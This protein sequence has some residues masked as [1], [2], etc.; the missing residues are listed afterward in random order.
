MRVAFFGGTFDPPHIGHVLAAAY[1]R[2]VGFDH[3]LVAPVNAHAFD[4]QPAAFGHRMKM[5]ELAFRTVDGVSVSDI[6]GRLSA[7]NYTL[8]TLQALQGEHP[9]WSLELLIGTDVLSETPRWHQFERIRELAPP[10]VLGR[11][12]APTWPGVP[13]LLPAISSSSIRE[14]LALGPETNADSELGHW[15][16]APVLDY[17]AAQQLYR[18]AVAS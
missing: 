8:Q 7:P 15:V 10:Y 3:V 6:E 14:R 11:Q 9:D 2:S 17:I 5:C 13:A 16:P 18:S 1:A 12:G 4:K